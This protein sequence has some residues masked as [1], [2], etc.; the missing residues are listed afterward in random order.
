MTPWQSVHTALFKSV[1]VRRHT[2]FVTPFFTAL[3]GV[4][5]C[6][7]CA[8][9]LGSMDQLPLHLLPSMI[10]D[11]FSLLYVS[12]S[13]GALVAVFLTEYMR[14]TL[15]ALHAASVLRDFYSFQSLSHHFLPQ[16]SGKKATSERQL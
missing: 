4:R 10:A 1:H 16:L 9:F 8:H 6:T 5:T 15:Q 13:L 3:S 12:F 2:G 11:Y 7:A 14:A